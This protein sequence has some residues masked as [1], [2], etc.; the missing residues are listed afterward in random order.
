M[1]HHHKWVISGI[2][3]STLERAK[4]NTKKFFSLKLS[5]SKF[6]DRHHVSLPCWCHLC[7][8]LPHLWVHFSHREYLWKTTHLEIIWNFWKTCKIHTQN[9]HITFTQIS[10][11]L[12]FQCMFVCPRSFSPHPFYLYIHIHA[13]SSSSFSEYLKTNFNMIAHHPLNTGEPVF[14]K[15]NDTVLHKHSA[16]SK[17]GS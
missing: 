11:L 17:S 15:G 12:I 6:S 8:L 1:Y 2:A 10:Q 4:S 7:Y 5:L 14:S 16:T 9:S 3:C 13:H